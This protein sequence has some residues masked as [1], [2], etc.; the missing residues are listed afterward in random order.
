[1]TYQVPEKSIEVLSMA[2]VTKGGTDEWV[3]CI[4]GEDP[5]YVKVELCYTWV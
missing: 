4:L 2:G 3:V 5:N 1:M